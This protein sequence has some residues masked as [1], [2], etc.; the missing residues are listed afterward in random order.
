[1]KGL[2]TLVNCAAILL[3]GG[4]GLLLKKG[5]PQRIADAI[6]KGLGLCVIA[7]GLEGAFAGEK[8]LVLICSVALGTAL[9]TLLDIDGKVNKLGAALSNKLARG[10]KANQLKEGFISATMLFCVGAMAVTGALSDGLS[11]DHSVLFTKSVIDGIS[12]ALLAAS[13]GA[14]VLLSAFAV[15][16]YQ[17]VFTLLGVFCASFFA[18]S[19]VEMGAVGSL[20]LLP[21]GLNMLGVTRLKVMDMVPAVFFPVLLCLFL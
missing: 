21:I 4:A 15:L 8:P 14:G 3:C 19:A 6:M 10:E 11:A 12:A 13:M 9:G 16:L 7:I 17:G 2:G 18:A 1:M 5:I 20:L